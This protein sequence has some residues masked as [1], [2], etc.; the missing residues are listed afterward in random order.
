MKDAY[1]KDVVAIQSKKPAFSKLFVARNLYN[2][3][4]KRETEN[5]FTE[6]GGLIEF[7]KWLDKTEV[8]GEDRFPNI[9]IV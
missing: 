7:A 1:E 6:K 2:R 3:L 9:N 5:Q 4:K 8:D